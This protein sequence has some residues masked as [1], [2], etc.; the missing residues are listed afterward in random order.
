MNKQ[1]LLHADVADYKSS[2]TITGP[3]QLSKALIV[4]KNKLYVIEL[5]VGFETRIT[6]NAER[7][8][9][10]EQLCWELRNN[11]D[12]VKGFNISAGTLGHICKDSEK[13]IAH[14]TNKQTMNYIL[15]KIG[16]C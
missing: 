9:N 6:I 13:L 8:K 7:K 1:L 11:F 16:A 5:T 15:N 2:T 14:L 12:E 4:D 10:H 3:S